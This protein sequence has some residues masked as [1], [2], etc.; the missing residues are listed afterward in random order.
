MSERFYAGERGLAAGQR[1]QLDAR[2]SR[3]LLRVMRAA[4]GSRIRVFGG[5]REFDAV[6]AGASSGLALVEI[7]AERPAIPAP[8]ISMSFLVPMLKGGRTQTVIQKLTELGA[9]AV[10][11]FSSAREVADV[12]GDKIGRF[13]RIALEACKQC[14]R[15][16]PPRVTIEGTVVSAV[17][18]SIIPVNRRI[19]LHE[20]EQ[21]ML[22]TSV[23]EKA[24]IDRQLLNAEK[25]AVGGVSV[26]VVSGPE[27]GFSPEE[28]GALRGKAVFVT[29]GPRILRAD[30][31]P[32]AAAA[33]ILAAAGEM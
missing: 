33:V 4:P 11:V 15:C 9:A 30:T 14:G 24:G 31:A 5:G 8:R 21:T 22:L 10:T 18:E 19:V 25:R 2:E 32:V 29:L 6:V 12:G 13:R 17:D 27:G 1:F 3:H 16:D 23:L 26:L 7:L 28:I 20:G